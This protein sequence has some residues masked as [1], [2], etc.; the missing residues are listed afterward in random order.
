M[1]ISSGK[2]WSSLI[3]LW[4]K[5]LEEKQNERGALKE[6]SISK[7]RFLRAFQCLGHTALV[8]PWNLSLQESD[9]YFSLGETSSTPA[10]IEQKSYLF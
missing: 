10:N 5:T 1:T 8:S 3:Y 7:A 9:D 2:R 4:K 6:K